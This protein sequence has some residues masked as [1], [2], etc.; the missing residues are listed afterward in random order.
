MKVAWSRELNS[1][2]KKHAEAGGCGRPGVR[3]CP[4]PSLAAW[5]PCPS[6]PASRR[7]LL[8]ST[9]ACA[10]PAPQCVTAKNTRSAGDTRE[11]RSP[12]AL[13]TA[14]SAGRRGQRML[15]RVQLP[16]RDGKHGQN[17]AIP[18]PAVGS[19]SKELE[20]AT[21]A[22][23]VASSRAGEGPSAWVPG[24]HPWMD[25]GGGCES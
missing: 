14:E 15:R 19:S 3:H 18:E 24:P 8:S 7:H 23:H 12:A 9:A 6:L 16:A 10:H 20:E 1:Q 25:T 22:R 4:A 21:W 11:A 17:P 2:P 5:P 13:V